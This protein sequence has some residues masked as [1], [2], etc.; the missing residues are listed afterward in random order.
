[1]ERKFKFSINENYHVYS[2][3]NNKQ[4]IFLR[5]WDYD[6]FIK[7]LYLCNTNKPILF[8]DFKKDE[9]YD[10]NQKETIV[11]IGA[12]CLMPNHFHLLLK[13]KTEGGISKFMKKLLTGYSM[14][15]N[16]TN[17]RTGTLFEGK[18]KALHINNDNYLKYLFAYIHLNPIKITNPSWKEFGTSDF[19]KIKK[20]LE[21]YT[22]SSYLDYLNKN[23]VEKLILNKEAFPKYFSSINGFEH[24]INE[25]LVF[26][27]IITDYQITEVGP[28]QFRT[29]EYKGI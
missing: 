15:F 12:Y 28:R 6:R 13:E 4:K 9:I 16:T 26:K 11:D 10:Y 7:L 21:Q 2:R 27:N 8:R 23:R 20:Y 5:H 14:Y 22:Y 17:S 24:F 19:K 29:K 1:M 18:F 3:G 25:W